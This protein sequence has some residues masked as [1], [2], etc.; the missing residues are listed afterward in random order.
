MPDVV[1]ADLASHEFAEMAAEIENGSG[2]ELPCSALS[3]AS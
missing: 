2:A 1:T 3:L